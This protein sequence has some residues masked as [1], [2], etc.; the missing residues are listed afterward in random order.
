MSFG[1]QVSN[2]GSGQAI[3]QNFYI[4]VFDLYNNIRDDDMESIITFS[5]PG[6]EAFSTNVNF[7]RADLGVYAL[8]GLTFNFAPG[9]DLAL[10]VTS[11]AVDVFFNLNFED[12]ADPNIVDLIMSFRNCKE[13]E[14][15]LSDNSCFRCPANTF[16]VN[17]E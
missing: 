12:E 8:D 13:G 5:T 3:D 14:I 16:L 15:L 10:A 4:V 6:N 17:L 1:F 9:K 11:N 7:V 2:V